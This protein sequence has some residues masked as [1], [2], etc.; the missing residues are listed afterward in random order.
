MQKNGVHMQLQAEIPNEV[1]LPSIDDGWYYE[2]NRLTTIRG[3]RSMV[4]KET[5][6]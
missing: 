1:F 4:L 2:K 6:K 5:K 3:D